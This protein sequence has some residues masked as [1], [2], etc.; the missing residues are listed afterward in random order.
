MP[1]HFL[2]I[3]TGELGIIEISPCIS[4]VLNPVLVPFIKQGKGKTKMTDD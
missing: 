4:P 2:V 3:R 1:K